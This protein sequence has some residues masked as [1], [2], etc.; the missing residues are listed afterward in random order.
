M[1]KLLNTEPKFHSTVNI[2]FDIKIHVLKLLHL[3]FFHAVELISKTK[4][5]TTSYEYKA[6][7]Q[8]WLNGMPK[9]KQIHAN[10][11]VCIF[12]HLISFLLFT[13]NIYI[14][15]NK[16]NLARKS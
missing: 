3:S 14:D 12:H 15:N 2:S 13:D 1:A 7:I 4:E 9:G 10:W 5:A 11:V 8:H 16:C 6:H